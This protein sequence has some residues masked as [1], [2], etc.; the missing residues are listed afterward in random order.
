MKNYIKFILIIIVLLTLLG[1]ASLT[2]GLT[3]SIYQQKDIQLIEDGAPS[4]LLLIE[5]L[6]YAYPK[7]RDI[8]SFGIQLFTAY[9]GAFVEDEKRKAIF[10]DKTKNFAMDLL[11]TYPKF[12]KLENTPFDEYQEWTKSIRKKDIPYVFWGANAWIM[13]IISNLDNMEAFMQL[14]KA[15]VVLDRIYELDS[16]YYYGA[17]HLFYGI[18]YSM[19]PENVGGDLKLSKEEFD[20]ALK[21][22]GDKFLLT[23]V[24]YAQSY[25][26]A[27]Y[28]KKEFERVLNEVIN[29][30]IDKNPE[31]RLMNYFAQEQAA[32]LLDNVDEFFYEDDF[33]NSEW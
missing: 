17:P 18:Y 12:K 20:S 9:S 4:Y 16:G 22:S 21:Y 31:T 28:D 19:L 23:K 2:N 14:P 33:V 3:R 6:I 8:L 25:C 32:E 13:W 15:K 29:A 10:S 30:D 5:G 24:S 7:N 1:C 27:K 26:K 11:R